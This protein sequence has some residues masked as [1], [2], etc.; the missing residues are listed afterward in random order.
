MAITI[1]RNNNFSYETDEDNGRAVSARVGYD[2]S[3][4]T[5]LEDVIDALQMEVPRTM[6]EMRLRGFSLQERITNDY[7][8]F[9]ANYSYR[10]NSM[11]GGDDVPDET[12]DY[13]TVS[14]PMIVTHSKETVQ[15]YGDAPDMGGAIDVDKDGNIKG[16]DVSIGAASMNITHFF[17]RTQFNDTLRN[18]I[19][20]HAYRVNNAA[21]RGFDAG[22]V[23]Y[24][25]ASINPSGEGSSKLWQVVYH[26]MISPNTTAA[27]IEGFTTNVAKKGWEYVW[28]RY[29]RLTRTSTT[30]VLCYKPIGVYVERVYSSYDLSSMGISARG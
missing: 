21:F 12:V 10:A 8:Q 7:W 4:A 24:T 14:V 15:R 13:D 2:V 28:V 5:D 11:H 19:L 23:L 17:R 1:Q 20:F 29:G 6:G 18:K 9:T 27:E 30:P 26:Y 16:C 22:E 3:G 25:G